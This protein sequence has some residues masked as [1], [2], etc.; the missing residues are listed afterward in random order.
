MF[1]RSHGEQLKVGP[2]NSEAR[3]N[4]ASFRLIVLGNMVQDAPIQSKA[5]GEM[6]LTDDQCL[7][8]Y[9]EGSTCGLVFDFSSKSVHIREI[10]TCL[11]GAGVYPSGKFLKTTQP[12]RYL[13]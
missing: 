9:N 3:P 6:S 1:F 7:G 5:E 4:T 13:P 12:E 8:V 11:S 2:V 10:G